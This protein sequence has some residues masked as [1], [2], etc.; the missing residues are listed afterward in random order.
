MNHFV[1]LK[2]VTRS[3]IVVHDPACGKKFLLITEASKHLTGV[4][5]EL[6]PSEGFL[7]KDERA[8]LPFSIF[9]KQMRGNTHALV[10][11]FVLSALLEFFVIASPFYLQLTVDDVIARSDADLLVV[12]ALGF[13]L[14]TVIK[15]GSNAI[16][17][18]IMVMVQNAL[19]FQI[20]ARLFHHLIRLPIAYFEKRHIGDILSR[21]TSIEPIRNALAEGMIAAAIDGLMAIATLAMIFLYSTQ[22]A[23]VVMTAFVLYASV[24]VG[25]YRV[26]RERSQ[27]VIETKAQENSTF[28]ET[29]RAIQSLKLFNRETER[30]S[31]W[32]NRYANVVSANVSL[33]RTRVSFMTIRDAIFGLETVITIYLAARLALN[34][35]S[36]GRDD[37]CVHELQ[38]AFH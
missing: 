22:L 33:G 10:Q 4:A 18:L 16:R 11:I 3:G 9:W 30:E 36:D 14:L 7:L 23:L 26:F 35:T 1:V 19:H 29:V 31:L 38:A 20:G 2:S 21:F 34:N 6:S 13:G 37:F 17:S 25:L 27:A 15:V 28:I 8:R 24:R 12:L 5:L 32:L